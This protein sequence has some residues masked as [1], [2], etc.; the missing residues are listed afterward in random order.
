MIYVLDTSFVVQLHKNY[1]R[2]NFVTM[3]KLFDDMLAAGAFT[4][5]REV[6][7][8]LSE[9]DDAAAKWAEANNKLFVTPNAAEGAFVAGIYAIPHFQAN[10]E[11][12]KLLKGGKNADPFIIARAA[13]VKGTVLTMEQLKPH[14]AKIPNICDHFK[15]GCYDLRRFM[16]VEKWKF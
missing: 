4:S 10:M 7:R 9:S 6:F 13:A 12:Q 11:R 8:E 5:T 15:V 1:Y 3:W 16:E 14:A 2:E